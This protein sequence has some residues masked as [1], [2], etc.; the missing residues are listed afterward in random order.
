MAIFPRGVRGSVLE[1]NLA[2]VA[3]LSPAA[4]I[5]IPEGPLQTTLAPLRRFLAISPFL[6]RASCRRNDR[7]FPDDECPGPRGETFSGSDRFPPGNECLSPRGKPATAVVPIP[8]P[9]NLS[10]SG[11]KYDR[12][13]YPASR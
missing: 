9:D 12:E 3:V 5:P 1:T 4:N 7:S 10:D 8:P 11:G 13:S 6:R 2:A